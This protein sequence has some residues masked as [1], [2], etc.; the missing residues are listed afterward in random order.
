VSNQSEHLL[1]CDY[2]EADGEKLF[3]LAYKRD[4]EGI[5]AKRK[6][7]PYIV[8][9]ARWVKI[10]NTAYSQW[11]DGEKLFEREREIDPDIYLWDA[12]VACETTGE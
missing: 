3:K 11:M 1:Y 2:V 4:L 6:Y 10:R 12:C 7:D 5:V 9:E 8:G